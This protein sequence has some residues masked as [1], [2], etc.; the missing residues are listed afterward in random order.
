MNLFVRSTTLREVIGDQARFPTRLRQLICDAVAGIDT[1]ELEG[2]LAKHEADP[3]N[4]DGTIEAN[5]RRLAPSLVIKANCR[6][7]DR[8]KFDNDIVIEADDALVCLEIEKGNTSRFEFDIL[9]MQA[10]ASRWQREL[11]GKP[12]FGAFVVRSDNVVARHISGNA[13]ESSYRYL[14]RLFRLV[15]QIQPTHIEDI[16]VVG[17]AMEMPQDEAGRNKRKDSSGRKKR[18]KAAGEL[19]IQEKGLL[20][21]EALKAGLHGYP[22]DL[23]F[24]LRSR[25]AECCPTL[26]ENFNP[27]TRYLSYGLDGGS[28]D[29]FVYVQKKDIVIDIRLPADRAEDLRGQGFDVRPRNNY[30]GRAGWLTGLFVPHDTDMRKLL[31]ALALEA[32]QEE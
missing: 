25:L 30:Q 18:P 6:I 32:M 24:Y 23:I 4:F 7:S 9:K 10:F 1:E 11:P 31:V 17:Y 8:T 26:R 16:L 29:L 3:G 21:E 14:T 5:L 12:I 22:T 15:G 2:L 27:N 13:R 19:L 28:Y 20:P